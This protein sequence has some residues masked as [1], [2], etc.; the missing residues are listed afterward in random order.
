MSFVFL[1]VAALASAVADLPA[2]D[3]PKPVVTDQTG[4]LWRFVLPASGD[5]FEHAPFRALVLRHEKPEDLIERVSYRGDPAHRRYVQ[6]RFGSPGSTWVTV[7]LDEVKG[8][9]TDLYVDIDRNRK[10]DGHDRVTGAVGGT[11]R[12]RK[13]IWRLPLSVEIVEKDSARTIL[14]AV[15]FHL[16]TSGRTL[17]C[18]AVGYLDGTVALDA[19]GK[20]N[21]HGRTSATRRVNADGNGFVTDAQDRLWIDLNSDGRFDPAAEQLLYST[22]LNL[23][24]LRYVVRSDSWEAG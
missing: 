24:G 8:G 6:L 3:D 23:E 17:A 18:A 13:Q 9:E 11:N 2:S 1:A 14:R 21:K 5:P 12:G 7:V 10:I 22:V 4:Q 19:S 15:V 20:E 16:G